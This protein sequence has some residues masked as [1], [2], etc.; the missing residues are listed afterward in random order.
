MAQFA[1]SSAGHLRGQGTASGVFRGGLSGVAFAA[2]VGMVS[3]VTQGAQPVDRERLVT[4]AEGNQVF[5]L[6]GEPAL[7]VLLDHFGLSLDRLPETVGR[8]RGIFVGLRAAEEPAH[9]GAPRGLQVP[10]QFGADVVVRHIIGLDPSRRGMAVA[11][12]VVEGSHL[13]FCERS[14]QTASD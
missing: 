7:D 14:A 9:P 1:L 8:L 3:R 11:E 4:E 6:D 2:S 13:A 10:G 5:R 12:R